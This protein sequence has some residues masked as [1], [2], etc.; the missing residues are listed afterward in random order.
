MPALPRRAAVLAVLLTAAAAPAGVEDR[1]Y[2]SKLNDREVAIK[3]YTPPGYKK[4][5]NDR[6]PVVYN[7]H[8]AGGGSPERQWDRA[9]KTIA[10]AVEAGTID[11]VIYVFVNGLG[12]TFFVDY[13]DGSLKVESMI[14]KE[15]I[16]WVD[17]NYRTVAS[18][19]GRAVDGFSMGGY[20]A[21]MLALRHPD[22]FESVV[23]YGAALIEPR[24]E[25][26]KGK[27]RW[28][29]KEHAD[30]FDVWVLARKNADAVRK[31]VRVRMVCGDK[32]GLYPNNVKFKDLLGE[33]KVPVDWVPVPGVAHDTK[34]LYVKVGVESLKFIQA[35][36]GKQPAAQPAPVGR[37]IF[38]VD[39]TKG[40]AGPGA[41]TGGKWDG[42]WRTTGA[43][44]ERIVFDAGRA[45]ANGR[46]EVRVTIP[47]KPWGDGAAGK[48]NWVGLH[49]DPRLNQ[50]DSAGDLFYAR[51][52]SEAYKFSNVKAAGRA[53]DRTEHEPRV[54]SADDWTADDKTVHAVTLEWRDGVPVFTDARGKV[55]V[56]PRDK[57][58]ADTSV[59]ALRYAFLGSDNFTG[60]TVPG[61]RFLS[62]KLTDLGPSA[63][64]PAPERLKAHADGHVLVTETGRPVFLL[65]DT[66]WSLS[67]RCKPADVTE[68]LTT[69]RKQRFNAV[70]FVLFSPD[71]DA[72]GK[73][74][75]IVGT[76][77]FELTSGKPD[78]AKPSAA[79]WKHVDFVVAECKR[80]GLYALVLPA[81]GSAFVGDYSGKALD[82]VCFTE[83]SARAYGRWLGARYKGEPHVVY[84]LGGDRSAVNG[85][86]DS[87][88]VFRA[89][90]EG[91]ASADPAALMTYHPKKKAPQSSAWFHDDRWLSFHGIQH[92]PEDQVAAIAD[93]YKR[94]PPKPTWLFE[95]RYEGYW[96]TKEPE[97]WG[98]WQ[99]RQQ[100]YQTVF[101][102]AF[103]HTYGHE[104]VFGFGKD[105]WDW[106]KELDAP[107]ARSMT[108]LA[109]FMNSLSMG[110]LTTR[111]PDQSLLDGEGKAERFRSDRVTATRSPAGHV[112]AF[113]T[114][115]GRPVTVRL[116]R[117]AA[118]PMN[119]WWFNPRTGKWAKADGTESDRMTVSEAGV[120]TGPGAEVRAFAPP[121]KPG[122][123]NDWV[124]VLSKNP[125]LY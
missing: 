91:L 61:L 47:R 112:A 15:L 87:R 103:G 8:G 13:A 22:L 105:G 122:D 71:Q 108:H 81:W 63:A 54:G 7:L 79:Y 76:P 64:A 78:P 92:W 106:K 88:P 82:T 44:G 113:Y 41:V 75:D 1:T 89:L 123:G 45:V 80:L 109:R 93:D 33:L 26:D 125:A 9:G 11:P 39:L 115:A 73:P 42:G 83:E 86:R 31:G 117:L 12:D 55:T 95:G 49:E 114:A 50:N 20:G 118:G 96:K 62:A 38:D 51:V 43:K 98:E 28:G 97:K 84:V 21:L 100:A 6:Y 85:D 102:G 46:L 59:D 10:D 36:R 17:A 60:L 29:A 19:E 68:Y 4:D 116:D 48:V 30:Q 32:D 110:V 23:S 16:P 111:V 121:G 69:R 53:F 18:K 25:G 35:G 72:P 120:R 2:K 119:V 34:G 67:L 52:G 66:A 57:V 104:R 24:G 77:A 27:A 37:V 58:G 5:G 3:V 74:A 107:G 101:A 65:A 40:D 90:A 99:V 124:L 56:F 94:T 70:T 14:V